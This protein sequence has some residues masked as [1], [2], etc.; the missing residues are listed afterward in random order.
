MRASAMLQ[1]TIVRERRDT[2]PGAQ[3]QW[4]NMMDAPGS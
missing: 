4:I 2:L 1:W 3:R